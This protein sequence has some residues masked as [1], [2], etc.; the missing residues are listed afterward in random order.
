MEAIVDRSAGL[1]VHQVCGDSADGRSYCLICQC[2]R[3]IGCC[4]ILMFPLPHLTQSHLW[5][6]LPQRLR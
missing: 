3:D 5:P 1:D 2:S 6:A 4:L